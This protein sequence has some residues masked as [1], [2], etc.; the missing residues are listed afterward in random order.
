MQIIHHRY[1]FTTSYIKLL[2]ANDVKYMFQWNGEAIEPL[3]S[4]LALFCS[5]VSSLTFFSV[6]NW[7]TWIWVAH[8][9]IV[10]QI[11]LCHQVRER[12]SESLYLTKFKSNILCQSYSCNAFFVILFVV[13]E[14][15]INSELAKEKSNLTVSRRWEE[16]PDWEA[17]VWPWNKPAIIQLDNPDLDEE[18]LTFLQLLVG[19]NDALCVLFMQIKRLFV[20]ANTNTDLLIH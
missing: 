16:K 14:T 15:N 10:A 17:K 1:K 7:Q 4:D 6:C 12:E 20:S 2:P 5:K 3:V 11:G 9:G 18:M 8:C 13:N 19:W